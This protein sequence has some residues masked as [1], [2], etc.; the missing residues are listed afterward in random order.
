MSNSLKTVFTSSVFTCYWFLIHSLIHSLTF[1]SF[2]QP[3]LTAQTSNESSN[4]CPQS[5]SSS[6]NHLLSL[7]TQLLSVNPCCV[8]NG[9]TDS[10]PPITIKP[11]TPAILETME[12]E[13]MRR[14]SQVSNEV[15]EDTKATSDESPVDT[16][17]SALDLVKQLLIKTKNC[18]EFY[19]MCDSVVPTLLIM[20]SEPKNDPLF[21]LVIDIISLLIVNDRSFASLVE[22]DAILQLSQ[23]IGDM[24]KRGNKVENVVLKLVS[25][26]MSLNNTHS[27][28]Y[29][30]IIGHTH[31]PDHSLTHLTTAD[32]CQQ[33]CALP[34]IDL[35]AND[36]LRIQA[37][38]ALQIALKNES[39][40]ASKQQIKNAMNRITPSVC[41]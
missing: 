17:K 21:I 6:L 18:E 40:S 28:I 35:S 33:L 12:K 20:C 13:L 39:D 14:A 27:L 22:M 25:N 34:I 5:Y 8:S 9:P 31:L 11:H 2:D 37:Y 32:A 19:S 23:C 3:M 15:S 29:T 7:F 4:P 36:P 1:S 24:K 16:V 38:E 41:C 10:P 30:L 26:L